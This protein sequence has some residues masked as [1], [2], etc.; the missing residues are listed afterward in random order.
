M[1]FG[2]GK[3]LPQYGSEFETSI[4]LVARSQSIVKEADLT[5]HES[6]DIIKANQIAPPAP[7]VDATRQKIPETKQ[8]GD[9]SDYG[10]KDARTPSTLTLKTSVPTSVL[11][12]QASSFSG[13][14]DD[15]TKVARAP[16]TF[17][18]KTPIPTSVLSF[19]AMPHSGKKVATAIEPKKPEPKK[20]VMIDDLKEH[21]WPKTQKIKVDVLVSVEPRVLA[22]REQ[23]DEI[24]A[25]YDVIA[26]KIKDYCKDK[27]S[28]GYKP[29]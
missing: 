20:P 29:S 13:R 3:T 10:T 14:S 24:E 28:C 15:G 23:K 6:R 8:N 26:M 27:K 9:H 12:S 7:I 17:A 1:T 25:E 18:L 2:G 21:E 16:S 11:A 4:D 5:T 19:Q 22:L